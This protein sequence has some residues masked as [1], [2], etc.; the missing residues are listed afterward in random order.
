[1]TFDLRLQRACS[2]EVLD[3]LA[4][5]TGTS[6]NYFSVLKY[7]SDGASNLITIREF[8]D[9]EGLS[10]Y[11]YSRDGFSNWQL[12]TD[13]TQINWNSKGLGGPGTGVSGFLDGTSFI[14]PTPAMLISYRTPAASCPLCQNSTGLS[15]DIEFDLHGKLRTVDGSDKVRHLVFKTLLTT[16]GT[17]EVLPDYGSTLTAAIGEK[18]DTLMQFR[19]YNS[20]QQAVQF[21]ITE[22]QNQP[23][24]PLNETLL[25]VSKVSVVQDQNDPRIIRVMMEVRVGDFT[26][27]NINYNLVTA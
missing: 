1:M 12:S 27:V 4:T 9:T 26:T 15:R 8:S 10:N 6:P 2:H 18:F 24:L 19:I 16:L 25:G 23:T 22:Q 21:L 17:N 11:L 14:L 13:K 3:E 20:V 7:G 5:V